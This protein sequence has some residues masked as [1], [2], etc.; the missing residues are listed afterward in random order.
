M[1]GKTKKPKKSNTY[2][3]KNGRKKVSLK[4]KVSEALELPKELVLDIPKIT[5][6]GSKQLFLENYKGIIEYEEDK[7]R[8]KTNQG[9]ITLS[10]IKMV[11]KE[12]TSE[13]IMILGEIKSVQF[14]D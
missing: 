7:I 4:E 2:Q 12:I 8:V 9:V 14:Q 6:L 11:I 10:G 5:M 1:P 3:V 13:D